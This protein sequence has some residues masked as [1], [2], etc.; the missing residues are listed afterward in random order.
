MTWSLRHSV[1]LLQSFYC[2]NNY[3]LENLFIYF[4]FFMEFDAFEFAVWCLW[5]REIGYEPQSRSGI[6]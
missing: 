4:F 2:N 6:C 5:L 1:I 3:L